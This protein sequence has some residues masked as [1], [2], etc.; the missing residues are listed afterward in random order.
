MSENK[1]QTK[2][3]PFFDA[4]I[5]K[6]C[7]NYVGNKNDLVIKTKSRNSSILPCMVGFTIHV[8]N[9]KIYIP[10]FIEPN[11]IGWKLGQFSPTRTFKGHP[12]KKKDTGKKK[13]GVV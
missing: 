12:E 1:L 7:N 8:Y 4:S 3:I 11:M 2:R 5:F 9:G 10:V 13:R 6:K